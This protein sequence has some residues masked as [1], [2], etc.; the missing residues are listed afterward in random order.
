MVVDI[1]INPISQFLAWK[2][3]VDVSKELAMNAPTTQPNRL[4]PMKARINLI[5]FEHISTLKG[6]IF[7]DL[8]SI[9]TLK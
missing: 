5:T 9:L 4:R 8:I 3:H 1:S 2:S 7:A 6:C